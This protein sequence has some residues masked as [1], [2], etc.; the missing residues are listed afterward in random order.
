MA[1]KNPYDVLGVKPNATD[2][3][4]KKAYYALAKKY[5]PDHYQGHPLKQLAEEKMAEVNL[6][7]DTLSDPQKRAQFDME[8]RYGRPGFG[9]GPQAGPNPY[10][11]GRQGPYQQ[12][13]Y[14]RPHGNPYQGRGYYGGGGFNFCDSMML[15]CCADSCCECMGGDLCACC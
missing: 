15:L 3:E 12:N 14:Q 8:A 11:Q 1:K 2:Q 9:E 13:P 6:A 4:I 5:H 7:Y 10:Q